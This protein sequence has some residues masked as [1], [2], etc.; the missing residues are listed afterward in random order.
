MKRF[1][2]WFKN[3]TLDEEKLAAKREARQVIDRL[4]ETGGHDC[5]GEF[6]VAYKNLVP[7]ASKQELQKVIKQFHDSVDEKKRHG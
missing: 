6:V 4:L 2:A 3:R 7:D 5:E 1:V